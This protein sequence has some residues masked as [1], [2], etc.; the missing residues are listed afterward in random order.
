MAAKCG[1]SSFWFLSPNYHPIHPTKTHI[2]Q[3]QHFVRVS[4][5]MLPVPN[6]AG[7]KRNIQ[8]KLARPSAP[9][10]LSAWAQTPLTNQAAPVVTLKAA[11]QHRGSLAS[12][13]PAGWQTPLRFRPKCHQQGW[14][15]S[16]ALGMNFVPRSA[17][18]L[19][20]EASE[21][22]GIV[23]RDPIFRRAVLHRHIGQ[24]SLQLVKGIPD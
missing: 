15:R 19:S 2:G 20:L 18:I 5:K 14:G 13:S 21:P 6:R 9:V 10:T 11:L 24:P 23:S 12:R 8:V 16:I 3:Q 1:P 22:G 17:W 4:K 7:K